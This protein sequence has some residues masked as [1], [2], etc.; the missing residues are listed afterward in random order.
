MDLT[1]YI[2]A[3][4]K[5]SLYSATGRVLVLVKEAYGC[6]IPFLRCLSLYYMYVRWQKCCRLSGQDEWGHLMR[7]HWQL[8]M[9]CWRN[10][11][12]QNWQVILC[13]GTH[14]WTLWLSWPLWHTDHHMGMSYRQCT[15]SASISPLQSSGMR[16]IHG[17]HC[18]FA[19]APTSSS[20]C[21]SALLL[22]L[23]YDLLVESHRS[24]LERQLP[25]I[26]N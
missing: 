24:F 1:G 10:K 17:A 2:L 16:E 9:P 26:S 18:W 23:Q 13:Q 3:T 7:K 15:P 22:V 14:F 8:C 19:S 12:P 4:L 20:L 21:P 11:L 5:N 6:S 25:S